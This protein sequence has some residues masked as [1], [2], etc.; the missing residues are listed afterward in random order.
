MGLSIKYVGNFGGKDGGLKGA[1]IYS[2]LGHKSCGRAKVKK[3]EN[4]TNVFYGWSPS[5]FYIR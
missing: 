1:K 2:K 5:H 3:K 4:D